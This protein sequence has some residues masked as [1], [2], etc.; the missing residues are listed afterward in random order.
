MT[1][2]TGS[3]NWRIKSANMR[4]RNGRA[5]T[6]AFTFSDQ[7]VLL[8]AART[9]RCQLSPCSYY[10]RKVNPTFLGQPRSTSSFSLSLLISLK[11][12]SLCETVPFSLN[13]NATLGVATSDL[14]HHLQD[15]TDGLPV[16]PGFQGPENKNHFQHFHF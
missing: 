6:E 4:L 2:Q 14:I 13:L 10:P 11:D 7:L 8:P 9:K 5:Q 16:L 1:K 15:D 3:V 12:Q